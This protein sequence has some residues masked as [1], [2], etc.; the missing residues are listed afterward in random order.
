MAGEMDIYQL[1][2]HAIR[3]R[4]QVRAVY[5]GRTRH[6]CPHVLGTKNGRRRVLAYQFDGSSGSG[7]GPAG[8]S[9]NW[10]CFDVDRLSDVTVQEGPWHTAPTT[11]AQTC[12]DRIDLQV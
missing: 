9:Q 6:I 11:R 7:L 3:H 12:I 8:S 4:L 2:L 5:E 10:R 1:L